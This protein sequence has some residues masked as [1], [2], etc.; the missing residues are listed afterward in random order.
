MLLTC[1]VSH[2]TDAGLQPQDAA[3]RAFAVVG[4]YGDPDVTWSIAVEARLEQS[5]DA[6]VFGAGLAA[7]VAAHPHCGLPPAIVTAAAGQW[8]QVRAD[9]VNIPYTENA[10]MVRA[11][12]DADGTR[13]LVAAHHGVVDG[14]GLLALLSA[15]LGLDL[16]SNARG[17]A[18][19]TPRQ[20]FTQ[21]V[22]HRLVEVVLRPPRRLRPGGGEPG[23]GGD[24]IEARQ[25]TG[26]VDTAMLI[27][28]LA[29]LVARR[30][31]NHQS[32]RPT[33]AAVGASRRAQGAPVRPDRDTAFMRVLDPSPTDPDRN[34]ALLRQAPPQPDFP[35]SR[36]G[37]LAPL[38]TRLLSSRL[39]STA[40]VSNLGVVSGGEGV[41]A[42][43]TFYPAASG[44]SGVAVGAVSTG[45]VGT[46]S[47]RARAKDFG[48]PETEQMLAD[49]LSAL[50]RLQIDT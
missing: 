39:G 32:R 43:L 45:E 26:R 41:V 31:E 25:V 11:A 21:A 5:A 3:A 10:P 33:V 35:E 1:K 48:Q 34:R 14:L 28:A 2:M 42:E 20:T 24:R 38:A 16:R 47:V 12:V 29:G 13:V 6:E 40:L 19:S 22:R 36:A 15:A 50:R 30:D 46:V 49:L 23:E 17:V 44:P 37:G 4:L 9:L 18:G 27:T 7:L 8:H